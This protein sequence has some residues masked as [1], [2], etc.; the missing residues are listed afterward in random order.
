MLFINSWEE[1]GHYDLFNGMS[2]AQ[3]IAFQGTVEIQNKK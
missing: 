3:G 1:N 2:W